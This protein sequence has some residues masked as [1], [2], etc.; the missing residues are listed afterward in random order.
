MK[1]SLFIL[2]TALLAIP[3][4]LFAQPVVTYKADPGEAK[5][6]FE[7]K[8]YAAAIKIY[9]LLLKK[10][11]K[12]IE[13]NHKLA[14]SYL[15][16]NSIKEK[17]IRPLEYI[18]KQPK[19]DAEVWYDLGRAYHFANRFDDAIKVFNKFKESGKKNENA[20]RLIEMCQNGKI[21]IK[22]PV[23]VQ[24]ENLGKDIN[25]E[26]P[27]FYP[28]VTPDEKTLVFTSRRRSS[29][30]TEVE[31]DGFF[32]SDIYIS[33]NK[34][35]RKSAKP[36]SSS[37]EWS[38]VT[39]IG[40]NINTKFDEEVVDI[41]A[42]GNSIVFY[43]DHIEEFG[44]IWISNKLN[45]KG[46]Y[47]QSQPI[48]E[49]INE[50]LETSASIWRSADGE[51]EKLFFSSSRPGNFGETDIY[52]TKKIP[53]QKSPSGWEWGEPQNLGSHI[54]TKYR[55]EFPHLSTD[56][57]TLYFASEGHSSMGGFDI[58]KS[59]WNENENTW[60]AP[61]N[62]GYPINTS[63]D[64]LNISFTSGGRIAY[65]SAMREGGLG[66]LDIY[67]VILNDIEGKETIYKG[68]ITSGDS[69]SPKITDAVIN[70]SNK[71]NNALYGTYI[72]NPNSGY[73]VMALPPGRWIIKVEAAG[74]IPY[75]EDVLV[76]DKAV[77]FNPEVTKNIL[78]TK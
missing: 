70:V 27:D 63:D 56:G 40:T 18:I 16:S 60:S 71:K 14:Q 21:L 15:R 51:Q 55:E 30:S 67:R 2:F 43:V 64:N 36:G 22:H 3:A 29:T 13:Y 76:F 75:T 9:Q 41:S 54:N 46:P 73:Y 31:F 11:P 12:N 33:T 68:F 23:D 77:M 4:Y 7:N 5:K 39:S 47:L 10:E 24:F 42:D 52:T 20:D 65:M 17:A 57:K 1:K 53:S 62:L 25:C 78:L 50:G 34:G 72:P 69:L 8:N 19:F 32:P 49:K 35:D 66:D 38:K 48:G 61:K 45:G 44:D 74:Y 59:V 26:F 28:F 6:Q 37:G 58:F